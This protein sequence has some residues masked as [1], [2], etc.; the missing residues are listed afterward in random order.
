MYRRQRSAHIPRLRKSAIS[1]VNLAPFS[2]G[3][4]TEWI[5]KIW[6]PETRYVPV[7]PFGR[8]NP[9]DAGISATAPTEE[10]RAQEAKKSSGI[11]MT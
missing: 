11:E 9:L 4:L 8:L 3:I 7:L 6:T 10:S 2:G 1:S 5:A